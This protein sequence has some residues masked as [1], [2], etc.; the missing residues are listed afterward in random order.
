MLAA[1]QFGGRKKH[2]CLSQAIRIAEILRSLVTHKDYS[3]RCDAYRRDLHV[4]LLLMDVEKAFDRINRDEM[5]CKLNKIGLKG[6]LCNAIS[7]FINNRKQTTKINTTLSTTRSTKNGL[8]Q[9]GVISLA[10][11]LIYMNDVVKEVKNSTPSLFVD[12]LSLI[13]SAKRPSDLCKKIQVDLN[14][15]KKW[16]IENQMVFAPSKFHIIN[17]HLD[18]KKLTKKH[19]ESIVYGNEKLHWSTSEKLL[20]IYF[21]SK[22]IFQKQLI[23]T[24]KS[25]K[26]STH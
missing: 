16:S 17:I 6:N 21:D 15:I 14:N 19:K 13:A 26:R 3:K 9:G 18:N 8:P 25:V 23:E 2:S 24:L 7:A 12:D 10:C 11:F 5:I 1:C 22:L 4:C 20:G